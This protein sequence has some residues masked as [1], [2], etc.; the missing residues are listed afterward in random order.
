MQKIDA[1]LTRVGEKAVSGMPRQTPGERI[2]VILSKFE[3]IKKAAR[4]SDLRKRFGI[5]PT[6][7]KRLKAAIKDGSLDQ[8]IGALQRQ[9][10]SGRSGA[11][12]PMH[13][14]HTRV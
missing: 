4:M 10:T 14:R 9:R 6:L 11:P 13:M 3:A 2:R 8:P 7:E 5:T 12:A 1:Y